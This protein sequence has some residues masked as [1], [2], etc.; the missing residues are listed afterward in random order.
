MFTQKG[1]LTVLFLSA[2]GLVVVRSLNGT[3]FT[4][5]D[6]YTYQLNTMDIQTGLFILMCAC[7]G[8]LLLSMFV[9]G[10]LGVGLSGSDEKQQPLIFT[11]SE[12]IQN[13]RE[14]EYEWNESHRQTAS[15]QYM[16]EY[17]NPTYEDYRGNLRDAITNEYIYNNHTDRRRVVGGQVSSDYVELPDG[18]YQY[19]GGG[20]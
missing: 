3:Y 13:D 1:I 9:F 11:K 18:T 2:A 12:L 6:G 14:D 16:G 17:N 5:V 19:I 7:I 15:A 10:F 4:P 20:S 8:L